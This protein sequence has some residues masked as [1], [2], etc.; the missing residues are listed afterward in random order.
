MTEG[1]II[2]PFATSAP[3]IINT[4]LSLATDVSETWILT[5]SNLSLIKDQRLTN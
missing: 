5:C 1:E 3:W 2:N 4:Q